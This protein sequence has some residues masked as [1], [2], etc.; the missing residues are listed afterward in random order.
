MSPKIVIFIVRL[1]VFA[2]AA[3]TF[4]KMPT[5]NWDKCI[6]CQEKTKEPVKHPCHADGSTME[7]TVRVFKVMNIKNK[8]RM[9]SQKYAFLYPINNVAVKSG[10]CVIEYDF[11]WGFGSFLNASLH[12]HRRVCPS[13]GPSVGP[14]I[15]P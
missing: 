13:I 8:P 3:L 7:K 2:F 5:I 6:I 9:K 11:E 15:R 4:P 12:L 10:F 1:D 14:S